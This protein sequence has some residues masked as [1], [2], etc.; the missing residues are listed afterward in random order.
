MTEQE[1]LACADPRPMLASLQGRAGERKFRLFA[2]AQCR[3]LSRWFDAQPTPEAG[4][5]LWRL[6]DVGERAADA[7]AGRAEWREAVE[8]AYQVS[9]GGWSDFIGGAIGWADAKRMGTFRH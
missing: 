5:E 1:W 8:L 7:L 6:L 3:R 9:G 4:A 2:V